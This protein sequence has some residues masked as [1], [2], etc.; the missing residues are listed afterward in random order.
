MSTNTRP[1]RGTGEIRPWLGEVT[2]EEY[3]G[4]QTTDI[5]RSTHDA[6]RPAD[7]RSQTVGALVVMGVVVL[8]RAGA[9]RIPELL[10]RVDDLGAWAGIAYIVLYAVAAVAWVPGS[11]LTLATGAIFGLLQG[12][13]YTLVGATLGASLAFLVSRSVARSAV[14]AVSAAVAGASAGKGTVSIVA[15]SDDD[16]DEDGDEEG[17]DPRTYAFRHFASC[18]TML[19]LRSMQV[20]ST[21]TTVQSGRPKSRKLRLISSSSDA[22]SRE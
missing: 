5:D 2:T 15:A 8:A 14:A 16:D 18:P 3:L 10:R 22:E 11:I 12:T 21:T 7:F 17:F 1:G 6:R 19:R 4:P 9:D 20:A 13:A